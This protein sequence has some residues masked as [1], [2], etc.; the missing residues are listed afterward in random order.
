MECKYFADCLFFK[1]E[2]KNMSAMASIFKSR[3][4][5]SDNAE[6]ARYKVSEELGKDM[7]PDDLY[8]NDLR[9]I[10]KLL[11]NKNKI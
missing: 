2:M 5:L 11:L 10:E 6:C 3:Y 9:R 7:V 8:P 1:D 4:C